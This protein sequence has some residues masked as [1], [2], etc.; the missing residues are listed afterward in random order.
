[1]YL[2]IH[3]NLH[4]SHKLVIEDNLYIDHSGKDHNHHHSY[5]MLII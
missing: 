2:Y 3:Y 5:M 4:H 1:M